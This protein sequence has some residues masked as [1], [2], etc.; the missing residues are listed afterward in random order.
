MMRMIARLT[1]VIAMVAVGVVGCAQKKTAR[2][3]VWDERQ[4]KQQP[5]YENFLGN[6][7]AD[8]LRA[9]EGFTIRSVGMDDPQQGLPDEVLDNCDVLIWWGHQRQGEISI[10]TAQRIVER[11]KAGKLSLIVLHSA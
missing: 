1:L 3:V 2:V 8:H 6:H 4:P 11:V 5:T 7:I 10:E 9:Q